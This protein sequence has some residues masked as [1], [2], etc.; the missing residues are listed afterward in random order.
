MEASRQSF[1]NGMQKAGRLAAETLKFAGTLV[2]AGITTN[3]IDQAVY[4]FT[5]SKGAAPAPLNYKGFPKSVCT[6]VNDVIC[7]GVP[8]ETVL[9]NGDIIN[10][11][12][13][14][15]LNGYYGD[16]SAT[17]YVGEVSERAKAIT[18]AAYDAM[19][20]G[21]EAI[22]PGGRTGDIGFAIGKFVTKKGYHSVKDIGGHGIGQKFHMDP[23]VPS[24]GK[25]G[26]GDPL[27]PFTCITVEP[28]INETSEEHVEYSIPGSEIKYYRTID[29]T[30]SSQFEHTVLITDQGYEIM[31]LT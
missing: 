30:L 12:V 16:T 29:G 28:M 14:S 8:D 10:I 4:D 5:L 15:I 13:T 21:I 25:K 3:E 19:I 18:Q 7:H 11:D 9:K 17:F 24:F 26:R 20:K 6:S 1:V 23:F 2:K 31:T 22:E 27:R